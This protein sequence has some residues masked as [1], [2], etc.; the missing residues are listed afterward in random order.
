M[1]QAVELLY[2]AIHKAEVSASAI[3]WAEEKGS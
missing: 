2:A 3:R 1:D